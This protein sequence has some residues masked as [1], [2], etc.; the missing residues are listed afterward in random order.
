MNKSLYRLC[1]WLD[2]DLSV[3]SQG[4]CPVCGS[5]KLEEVSME[6]YPHNNICNG[7][8]CQKCGYKDFKE[9]FKTHSKKVSMKAVLREHYFYLQLRLTT[10]FFPQ[11]CKSLA[12]LRAKMERDHA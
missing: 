12:R 3:I 10:P 6:E 4:T 2:K 1:R 8:L 11:D 9:F 7:F 5:D